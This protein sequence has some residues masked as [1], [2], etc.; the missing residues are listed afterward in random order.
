MIYSA[1]LLVYFVVLA[2]FLFS[3]SFS[4]SVSPLLVPFNSIS[5]IPANNFQAHAQTCLLHNL[6][7]LQVSSFIVPGFSWNASTVSFVVTTLLGKSLLSSSSQGLFGCCASGLW[8][9][10][11]S[12]QCFTSS[13]GSSFSNYGWLTNDNN[14]V[15]YFSCWDPLSFSFS[16]SPIEISSVATSAETSQLK[17]RGKG[18][19]NQ[20][21][22]AVSLNG[23]SCSNLEVGHCKTCGSSDDCP[24]GQTCFTAM[25]S[26]ES[27]CTALC[28]GNRDA[29]CP[30]NQVCF[31]TRNSAGLLTSLCLPENGYSSL[32]SANGNLDYLV[33]NANNTMYSTSSAD[34]CDLETPLQGVSFLNPSSIS[35]TSKQCS[36]NSQCIDGNICTVDSCDITSGRCHYHTI[37]N[38]SSIEQTIREQYTPYDFHPYIISS[39]SIQSAFLSDILQH[40][41]LSEKTNII[42]QSS[43]MIQLPWSTL[44]FGNLINQVS[45]VPFG[46]LSLPP[47]G[48]CYSTYHE[49]SSLC[50]FACCTPLFDS[51]CPCFF[52]CFQCIFFASA[53]NSISPW[54]SSQ[55]IRGLAYYYLQSPSSS[56]I[57]IRGVNTS[58]LHVLFANMSFY[59]EGDASRHLQQYSFSSSFYKDGSVRY[60]YFGNHSL[61]SLS[62]S[63]QRSS[64]NGLWGSFAS[65]SSSSSLRYHKVN[66]TD[67]LVASNGE[68]GIDMVY[69]PFNTTVCLSE[70]CVAAGSSLH[71]AWNG[72]LSC[73]ALQPEY[74]LSISC[75]FYGGLAVSAAVISRETSSSSLS[76]ELS[77]II[78][79]LP[80]SDGSI[81]PV[82]IVFT[83]TPLLNSTV[84]SYSGSAIPEKSGTKSIYSTLLGKNNELSRSNILI[85]YYS[86]NSSSSTTCGCSPLSEY[87][88]YQCSKEGVC[89]QPTDSAVSQSA[90][91]TDCAGT[92]FG[93]A[94]YDACSRCSG[95]YTGVI[96]I[97]SSSSCPSQDNASD[98]GMSLLTQTIILLLVICCMTFI[99]SSIAY[100][101]RRMLQYRTRFAQH[102]FIL[103]AE[104]AAQLFE[105]IPARNSRN[106]RGAG[107]GLSDF[108]KDALGSYIFTKEFYKNYLLEKR[109]KEEMESAKKRALKGEE[110]RIAET[111]P[112]IDFNKEEGKEAEKKGEG[113]EGEE[114]K[115]KHDECECPICLMDIEEG[116]ECRLLPEP[117]GHLFHLS[118][119]DEWFVQSS[120]CPLCKRSMKS[121]LLGEFDDDI[122]G[123]GDD[124][125]PNTYT[126]NTSSRTNNMTSG[127]NS[128]NG[129][130]SVYRSLTAPVVIPSSPGSANSPYSSGNDSPS[131]GM[132]TTYRIHTV[133]EDE[134]GV[135]MTN[136]VTSTR[137][138]GSS[139][140]SSSHNRPPYP[141]NRQRGQRMTTNRNGNAYSSLEVDSPG[142]SER[143]TRFHPRRIR[144]VDIIYDNDSE[145]SGTPSYPDEDDDEES[146]VRYHQP[147]PQPVPEV[148]LPTPSGNNSNF[149][150]RAPSS[151]Q[152]NNSDTTNVVSP[153]EDTS[154]V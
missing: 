46:V 55:W 111:L 120:Q 97:F 12:D 92:P 151:T 38:C 115:E 140:S 94:Y 31:P 22:L 93:S 154:E 51:I 40:G 26:G 143:L 137:R 125:A 102:E 114:K 43:E 57:A 19:G 20:D 81:V 122:T 95:G 1:F 74:E 5:F 124:T 45:I 49:V 65:I 29:S 61:L 54:Y 60:T 88:G 36:S 50:L 68:D 18:F 132:I 52:F 79:S 63:K 15:P 71:A 139:S 91:F 75:S 13:F 135:Y 4:S 145:D 24:T 17:M 119:I 41:K 78:P 3:I 113:G 144:T 11:D 148:R 69:C 23:Q 103:D 100:T 107:R 56:S 80:V 105:A 48:N 64:F 37:V 47:Y 34:V 96:P 42:L 152:N 86:S 89:I 117:C 77:C 7:P 28:A 142:N 58:A 35:L 83:L 66:S 76:G 112:V 106:G 14:S 101:I 16:T 62:A 59:H 90:S 127:N 123:A 138:P 84:F 99:T 39:S 128:P 118:C 25:G 70:T 134:I 6:E 8:C 33:C 87:T 153:N 146:H 109:K 72:S 53:L 30:C 126:N 2:C 27:Y 108:E 121:I 129:R 110:E 10:R 67:A 149:S 82:E 133:G 116:S 73:I 21:D 130:R 141:L 44:Y 85:R 9:K 136:N 147:Q 104:L 150:V 131:R 32:C 98:S